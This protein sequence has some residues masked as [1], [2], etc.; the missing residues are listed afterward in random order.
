MRTLRNLKFR[1]LSLESLESRELLSVNPLLPEM[2]NNSYAYQDTSY[3]QENNVT[4]TDASL[5]V[6][7]AASSSS[8]S[9]GV[10]TN[11]SNSV[12]EFW[13]TE[14]QGLDT[15][16]DGNI[17]F[18]INVDLPSTAKINTSQ[19][20][21]LTLRVWDVDYNGIGVKELPERDDVFIVVNG[22]KIRV[23][24][25]TGAGQSWSIVTLY[26]DAK[27]LKVGNNR[28]RIDVDVLDDTGWLVE[29][30]WAQL[31]LATEMKVD[32]DVTGQNTSYNNLPVT[33]E[34]V[35]LD[36]VLDNEMKSKY[37]VVEVGWDIRGINTT[38]TR[39][40]DF[41]NVEQYFSTNDLTLLYNAP[42]GSHGVHELLY[43]IRLQ[44]K[45]TQ[46]IFTITDRKEFKVFFRHD[47]MDFPNQGVP[48]W[49]YYW[50]QDGAVP[51][52]KNSPVTIKWKEVGSMNGHENPRLG[53]QYNSTERIIEIYNS[54]LSSDNVTTVLRNADGTNKYVFYKGSTGIEKLTGTLAHEIK[55]Y[56]IDWANLAQTNR[57]FNIDWMGRQLIQS[58]AQGFYNT[59]YVL[60]SNEEKVYLEQY[61]K[62]ATNNFTNNFFNIAYHDDIT[63][64]AQS[65]R[66]ERS[67][68]GYADS[69]EE[70][71][72]TTTWGILSD[73]FSLRDNL[74]TIDGTPIRNNNYAAYGDNELAARLA[75]NN[76]PAASQANRNKDWSSSGVQAEN[77]RIRISA[78]SASGNG[79]EE[80]VPPIRVVL[81]ENSDQITTTQFVNGSFSE[82][83][84]SGNNGKY[85]LVRI[86][87]KLNVAEE[88][89]YWIRMS[90]IDSDSN[91]V[92]SAFEMLHLSLGVHTLA[93][94][95]PSSAICQSAVDG[96]LS[97]FIGLF[98]SNMESLELRAVTTRSYQKSQFTPP[99][100]IGTITSTVVDDN[101]NSLYDQLKFSVPV[102][103]SDPGLYSYTAC[104]YDT[105]G[106]PVHSVS[107]TVTLDTTHQLFNVAFNGKDI[108]DSRINGP[109]SLRLI[110]TSNTVI[111]DESDLYQTI[112][113]NYN[114]F[115]GAQALLNGNYSDHGIDRNSD[116]KFEAVGINVGIDVSKAGHYELSG[117]LTDAVG[118][119]MGD[120]TQSFELV[121]GSQ[122]VTL[123]FDSV[124]L[125][126]GGQWVLS[127][128]FLRDE[129]TGMELENPLDVHTTQTYTANQFSPNVIQFTGT[130][131]DLG[132]D[133]NADGKFDQLDIQLGISVT[134]PGDYL[135]S[136]KLLDAEG[137][138][139]G[140]VSKTYTLTGSTNTLQ[141]LV[142]ADV[143]VT[144][145]FN[146]PYQLTDISLTDQSHQ[147]VGFL[148]SFRTHSYTFRHFDGSAIYYEDNITECL[149]DINQD[150]YADYLTVEMEVFVKNSGKYN[151]NAQLIN[152]DG[153]GIT[154]GVVET[155]L[156]T[157]TANTV[158]LRFSGTDI[159]NYGNGGF[160][161]VKNLS[162]YY[163]P[164][165][166]E[167]ERSDLSLY[168]KDVYKT[169][170]EYTT[171][172]FGEPLSNIVTT[173][174]DNINPSDGLIS[175][176]EAIIYAGREGLTSTVTF[177]DTVKNNTIELYGS[178]IFISNKTVTIDGTDSHIILN[179]VE[180]SRVL[181]I[182]DKS[183]VSI[184]GLDLTGGSSSYGGAILN[185]GVL[186]LSDTTI[187][188]NTTSRLSSYYS[189][190]GGIYNEGTLT[191]TNSTISKNIADS[192]YHSY[193]GGIYSS[194]ILTVIGSTISEN[195]AT[196]SG[197]FYGGG[198][199][200]SGTLTVINSVISRNTASLGGGIY[201]NGTATITNATIA[202]NI[203]TSYGGGIYNISGTLKL[204]NTIVAKNSSDIYR[205]SGTISGNN[206]FIGNGIG[207]T[208]LV[209]GVDDNIVSTPENQID[210]LLGE[211]SEDAPTFATL[212]TGS[213]LIN[214]GNNSYVSG[215][216]NTDVWGNN[217]IQGE[218]VDIGAMEGVR[219]TSRPGQTYI[220]NSFV[221]VIDANDGLLTFR[222]ALEAANRN[223]AVGDA[224]AGSFSEKDVIKFADGL[225]GSIILKGSAF[226]ILG[227]VNI[228]GSGTE[229]LTFDAENRSSIFNISAGIAV[230]L[231][232]MTITK[233]SSLYGDGIENGGT[234]SI[235]NT[236]IKG[237]KTTS[238]STTTYGGAI[239][240]KYASIITIA[241]STITGNT[242]SSTSS[243]GGGIYNTGT[244]T[245]T[246]STIS[247]NTASSGGGIYNT[248]TLT[249]TSSTISGN[250]A[251]SGGGIYNT[252][253]LTVTSSTISGNTAASY[254]YYSSSGG[255]IYSSGTLTVTNSMISGNTAASYSYYSSSGGGIYN[256]G[257]ATVTNSTIIDDIASYGGGI[258]NNSGTLKLYNTIVAKNS[259]DIYQN[260]GT[261]SGNNNFI[262]NGIGQ[263]SLVNGVGG[264]IVSTP[265][266]PIDPLLGEWSED[267]A[268]F[269]TLLTGSP[270]I[271][272]GNNSYVSGTTDVLGNNR[273]KNG[274]VDIGAMEGVRFTSRPGQTYLVTSLLDVIDANDGLLTFREAL[275]A[276]NRNVAVG[277]APAGSFSEKDTI[278]FTNGLSGTFKL[279]GYALVILGSVDI[280]GSGTE[281]L[282]F[283][284]EAK[285]QVFTISAGIAVGLS[286][287]SITNGRSSYGYGGG[288]ENS[289]T[290]I[291]TNALIKGNGGGGIHNNYGAMVTITNSTISGNTATATTSDSSY[292]GGIYNSGTLT[293]ISSTISGNTATTSDS[294]YGGGIYNSGTL[295]VTNS[296]IYGNTATTSGSSYG[297]GIYNSGT[298]T[299]TN[300]TIYGNTAAS[301]GGGIYNTSGTLKLYNTIIAK[302][303]S[304]IYRN[305]GTISGNNN[306]IGNG[307]GQTSFT[308]GIDGNI[309]GTSGNPIDPLLRELTE[310]SGIFAPI[311]GSPVID[312]GNNDNVSGNKDILGED[313]IQNGTVDMGAVEGAK[314][315][316]QVGTIYLVTSLDDVIDA[317]DG[318]LTFREAFEAANNNIAVGDA[319]AGSF[320][321][322]DIIQFAD[323][324][325]GTIKLG[326]SALTILD[327]LEIIGSGNGL[328]IFDAEGKS[329][330]FSING[331]IAVG[332][333]NMTI[334]N[335]KSTS[336]GG[337]IYN[338][339]ILTVTNSTISGNTSSSSSSGGGIYNTGTLTVTNSTISGN[340]ASS[341]GG[342]ICNT[343]T[344]TVTNST[345]SGNTA[346]A[347]YVGGG[348]IYNNGTLTV[349]NCTIYGN[350]AA[351][352][353]GGIYNTGTLTVTNSTISGNTATAT[354]TASYVG[355]GGIYNNGTLTV[356]NCTIYGNT[357]ATSGGGIVNSSG[358]LKLYNTIVAKN[359]SDIYHYSGAI[360]G[361]NNLIG[362]GTGQTVFSNGVNGNIV[363]TA[364]NPIDPLL[365][366]WIEGAGYIP[367]IGSP[368]FD[369]GN[370]GNV[371]ESGD[372]L[373]NNRI[374]NGT[375][376][377]GSVEG[378]PLTQRSGVT[379]IVTSLDD[380]IDANDGKL[381]FREAFEAANRN[382]AVGNA[383]AGSFSEKDTITFANGL[384]GTIKTG[385]KAF[386]I[387]GS[388][389]IIGSGIDSLIF[390]GEGKSQVFVISRSI[391]AG[392]SDM[393]ITSGLG[394]IYNY[395]TLVMTNAAISRNTGYGLYNTGTVTITDSA[396]SKNTSYG[397]YNSGIVTVTNSTISENTVN[398]LY[399]TGTAT[400]TDSAISENTGIGLY[401][402]DTLTVANSM[403][404]ENTGNGIYNYGGGNNTLTVN[405]SM[406]F[407]NSGSGIYNINDSTLTIKNSTI[408]G[409]T[410]NGIY[411][412]NQKTLTIDN[413][414]IAQNSTD[415]YDDYGK[416]DGYNNLIGNGTGQ[417]ALVDG[418]HGNHVGTAENP[419]DPML[420]EWSDD[421][422]TFGTPLAGSPVLDAGNNSY[423]SGDK[424]VLGNNRIQNGTVDIGAVEG[425][426]FI[427]RSG[428]TYIVTSLDDVI[429]ANDGKLTFREAFEAAN[430]NV[431]VGNAQAGSFSEKDTIKFA[432]G[433]SG[434]IKTGGNAF[435]ILGSVDIIGS[436]TNLLIFDGEKKSQVFIISTGVAA[437][438]SN[439]T[440]TNGTAAYGTS[441]YGGGI[442]NYGTLTIANAAIFGNTTT[443]YGGGGGGIYNT[444]TLTVTDSVI[445]ENTASSYGGGIYNTGT[446]TVTNSAISENT[447]P[448]GGG[449]YG[450]G[451][452]TVTNSIISENTATSYGGGIYNLAT[453]TVIN[454]TII[455]NTASAGGGIYNGSDTLKSKLYNT[456]VA[457]NSSDIYDSYEQVSGYNNLIGDGSGQTTLINDVDGNKVGT[458]WN[459][460]DPLLKKLSEGS[461]IFAPVTSSPVID[462]GNNSY[463]S[464][465]KDILGEDRIQNGTVNIGAVE[466]IKFIAPPGVTYIVTSLDD[467]INAN[468][469]KLTFRE[470][471]EAANYNVAVGNAQAGSYANK[472]IIRFADGLS[473]TIKLGGKEL[474]I[475]DH[476]EIIGSGTELLIFDGENQSRIFNI[477][478]GII[479]GL[480]NMT[481]TGGGID[482]SGLL[483][484]TD[485]TVS[486]SN[487][488][489]SN[490]GIIYN[491]GALEI[492]NSTISGI[493]NSNNYGAIYNIGNM[494]VTDSVISEN[495]AYLGGGIYNTGTL[496]VTGS[497]I[498]GNTATNSYGGG[499]YNSG[500]FTVTSS[501]ISGNTATSSSYGGGGIYNNTG[502]ITVTNSTIS[503][504]TASSGGGIYGNG[505]ITV[506]NTLIYG[507][508]AVSGTGGG[509]NFSGSNLTI[510]NCTIYANTASSSGGGIY[511]NGTLKIYNTIVAQ[512]S[513]DIY[514]YGGTI[515]GNNNLIGNGTGQTALIQDINGNLVGTAENPIDPLLG[516]WSEGTGTLGAPLTN[517]PVIN[518]GNN[519]FVSEN[520]DM[521][522]NNRIQ[523]GTVDIGAVEGIAFT[524]RSGVTYLVTSLDDV[525]DANDGKLTFREAFEAANRN[526]AVGNAQAGSFSEKDTIT[527]ANG[528]SGTIKLGGNALKILGSIDIIGSGSELL[529][530]DAEGKSQVFSVTGGIA[531]GLS[532]MT[533]ANGKS[534]ANGGGIENT[535]KL[536]ITNIT[537]SGNNASKGGGIYNVG[538]LIVTNSTISDNSGSGIYNTA[539]LT[540]T[541]STISGNSGSGIYNSGTLTLSYSTIYENTATSTSTYGYGGGIYNSGTVTVTNSTIFGNTASYYGGGIY[542][543]GT[544]NVTNSTIIGNTASSSGGG[545]YNSGTL[546]L[547]NTIVAKNSSDIYHYSGITS[548][549]NNLIGNGSGQTSLTNNVYGNLV[550][551]AENPIDPFLSEWIEGAGYIPLTG[552]PVLD[553]GNN[554]YVAEDKDIL[555]NNRI[556]NGTVDIG[557]V[558]GIPLTP[559]SGVTYLVTSLDDVIDANDGKLT[560]REAFEAANRNVAV[561]NAQAGSFSEKD[562]ITFANG[563][564]GTIKLGGNVLKILG[565]I[566]IIGS[567]T[568]LLIFDGEGKS[569]VFIISTGVAAGLSNMTITNGTSSGNGGGIYNYGTLTIANTT[570]FGNTATSSGGGIYNTGTLTVTNSTISE[571]TAS[572]YGG[573]IY[574]NSGTVTVTNST[575]SGNIAY[576][577]G[578]IYNTGTLTVT[579][580][581]ISENTAS[582]YGGGIYNTGT[583]TVTNCTIYENTASYYGGGIYNYSGTLNLYNT[584]V[585]KNIAQTRSDIYDYYG[586]IS[587]NNNFI[588]DGT[589]QTV[590]SNG[591][592]G[593]IVGT[594][595]NPID[596]LLSEWIDGF[597]YIPLTGSPVFDA[598]NNAYVSED[599][600]ISGNNRIQ[601][602]TVDIGA[603][604]GIPLTPRSGVTYLVTSLDDVIDA[605]DGK[606]TFREAFEAANRNVAVGNAQA[607][608]FS[609]K[610]TITFANGL[611]GTIKLGGKTL[612]ILGSINIIGS[613]TDLLIFDGE[614]KSQVFIISTGVAAGL[615][616]MTITNGTSSVYGGG[617]Y[618]DGTLTIDLFSN[619]I[620]RNMHHLGNHKNKH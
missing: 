90:A 137:R 91:N 577:G 596:P 42:V 67:S 365:S 387:L 581:T 571:N 475:L 133:N 358:T 230:G 136:A 619:L 492:T 261:I 422:K 514:H 243:G 567:S 550:G 18:D 34:R 202:G 295:T 595:E 207:Q 584:I 286:N 33:G 597:G 368:V 456:I 38:A 216:N 323:G 559:R 608:S 212:L 507:N 291:I 158:R 502:T 183:N 448:S 470:A 200:S 236:T 260:G 149:E 289:G 262:G 161:S 247:G 108:F 510:T 373:G 611:S 20:A 330:V 600:D 166:G 415:L 157:G 155:Y 219:F 80:P 168:Q 197:S 203:T 267:T 276:A 487:F 118:N 462:A 293:V 555:G 177:S 188:D 239:Y 120:V 564:S 201:N 31:T 127:S 424:D 54:V 93:I 354:A 473:G 541:N 152:S 195:I 450:S 62:T 115:E 606:L 362:V 384:S 465:N 240:N 385:G 181:T 598:G 109:Y 269:A 316:P 315:D 235:T 139:I 175:L 79:L 234:L 537:I 104:L 58:E 488:Y 544:I 413:T 32:L 211:W 570:I 480:S 259:S 528:L 214:A 193:G 432:N 320:S 184:L 428:V 5:P 543:N 163:L 305:G 116:G 526:I 355:G 433:L 512:N 208:S 466:G 506:T 561:G 344:L 369:A 273:I 403:I 515:S 179:A 322:K 339:G 493:S 215:Y 496:T 174:L 508:T 112:S 19:Q 391:V 412:R 615:S 49:F 110:L 568:D 40:S 87:A 337:G 12:M 332:L 100:Q 270:L 367:L 264:N 328:L 610:D 400:I 124:R 309:V 281:L 275:E 325:F 464:G 206:N 121:T 592:N 551:T 612:R 307:T 538:T 310:G 16:T 213:P 46:E 461:G 357:A 601:N 471:F 198:I 279:G 443:A 505:T 539:K 22:N 399:N 171:S 520:K 302:N 237:N 82:S 333:S 221:D 2:F 484:V 256:S 15:Y 129:D 569:Q 55:H 618:N 160:Y 591:V 445:S 105:A 257:T 434:T 437:G 68:D 69:L 351:S 483:T 363:G 296:T 119:Y 521:L 39:D 435:T 253:T 148:D 254:S 35:K 405:N 478:T 438:L 427:P 287:M 303:S 226:T 383:Q 497:T 406:I 225:T 106:E 455:G 244:L 187:H 501:T 572:S 51:L 477:A 111:F 579:N 126:S 392:L 576:Y 546:R 297:G 248:G 534:S 113:Y 241:N 490:Y 98:D 255:G 23:G 217:R 536:T 379:Y 617:I 14:G 170:A 416:I 348:G 334:T 609:E 545:I 141:L 71:A 77:Y 205:N 376:D 395:G 410:V 11:I 511:N 467:V 565:S 447:A 1:K 353:G 499:I 519:E 41:F 503:G 614:G 370:N 557:A 156:T 192:Q 524:P 321:E 142:D 380:V 440:I 301:S 265:E 491:R 246:S 52:L 159:H 426:A 274:T 418:I 446:L 61:I 603:V 562:T 268:T 224:P 220:I 558:E 397:I 64:Q 306:F 283:D 350:T 386:T 227:S 218:R 317:N 393:T 340:T 319:L 36:L 165:E 414:I 345:I 182:D 336:N 94:D 504:N 548:G 364:E 552:S 26:F 494:T 542:N 176:R 472:D 498:S 313:R 578:G 76:I 292:G 186:A 117:T 586:T 107:G 574:N 381:T 449:I 75:Q 60:G 153:S 523:N 48:N 131:S 312:S 389:D 407:R 457:K 469:N 599:K 53:G 375:V 25:L 13:A 425:I 84:V 453:L 587:G 359:S 223:V 531:V 459:P 8:S 423:I 70:S 616:N 390:D 604:E 27:H 44:D 63:N 209:N 540:V 3:Q 404:Y 151:I 45:T 341:S 331:G 485:F 135:L 56:E 560:F 103:V 349:T 128:L 411:N 74:Y 282:V 145:K 271:D 290:L 251:S 86:Q 21:S 495:T 346:T 374:Q 210:P 474:V 65:Y 7:A 605:N 522:G 50:K 57:D 590:F 468:D 338:N 451:T 489:N 17:Q 516:E 421:S 533:I 300:S 463:V 85:D 288:I 517:S 594:A 284:A 6:T 554:A 299:V 43:V 509:I 582:S 402:S 513:S 613:G 196:G 342:G 294:S 525:I 566:D 441:V 191:V 530:F 394:G 59:V 343:G 479:V 547:Y 318:K 66:I 593:N 238:N 263:T 88:G 189:Y 89:D 228:I 429:D 378:T 311:T 47:K 143:F 602:G 308:N 304:D 388:V 460:I 419:I 134:K 96:E 130:N 146:G 173:T 366:E 78:Q 277:N 361:N 266:N 185:L 280:I 132:Q 573:G 458:L 396:I 481:L 28:I 242:T 250:T 486:N 169:T 97:A 95:I 436:G 172:Q 122:A 532:N 72:V 575:I 81:T 527:F 580:S 231:S 549:Y 482:N 73:T 360:S 194:G 553:T 327:H 398:G 167:E 563:L 372:L 285:S 431:A 83:P 324:L 409:N 454:S 24:E 9:S 249:V 245:V 377:I 529:I 476:L 190:G 430:R 29:C 452:I 556:Q 535:G 258:Y 147:L 101:S 500:T 583:S 335:G 401:N 178:S 125:V 272:A 162:I 144:D 30:D 439:M 199:Y 442:Y 620:L 99:V 329:Q 417:T 37:N 233:G 518:A 92:S 278:R 138:Y 607:G 382:V 180:K 588:G 222:E 164:D 408:Y 314:F 10:Y 123:E 298:L 347:S 232:N 4:S 356:T 352:S 585:A 326:G 140:I 154:W 204:Y 102:T 252:G 229:L 371:Y 150:G 589:G 420:G 444:G 114:Q